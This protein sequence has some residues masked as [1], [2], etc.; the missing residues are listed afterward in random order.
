MQLP[1]LLNSVT[2]NN[3]IPSHLMKFILWHDADD[4]ADAEVQDEGV[5]YSEE[6]EEGEEVEEVEAEKL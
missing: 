3:L 4:S 2:F 5:P 1:T 6:D